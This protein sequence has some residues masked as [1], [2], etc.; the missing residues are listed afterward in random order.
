MLVGFFSS[1]VQVINLKTKTKTNY[2]RKEH[3]QFAKTYFCR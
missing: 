2:Q 1:P 3:H